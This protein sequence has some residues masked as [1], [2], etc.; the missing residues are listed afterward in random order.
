M[1]SVLLR[2]YKK[3][4]EIG[5]IDLRNQIFDS[6]RHTDLSKWRW[7]YVNTPQGTS[8]IFLYED[9]KKIVGHYALIPILLKYKDKSVISGK[10]E[11][12]MMHKHYRGYGNRFTKL[13]KKGNEI[14]HDEGIDIIWGFPNQAALM[15]HVKGGYDYIGDTFSS[16]KIVN[17][18]DFLEKLVPSYIKSRFISQIVISLGSLLFSS[19]NVFF[20]SGKSK[21]AKDLS[22]KSI[23]K[24]DKRLNNLWEK[25]KNDY[26]IT[27]VRSYEYLNW[28]FVENPCAKS[29]IFIAEKGNEIAGYIVLGSYKSKK[30]Q[31]EAGIISDFFFDK[32]EKTVLNALLNSAIEYFEG[33]QVAYIAVS[34]VKDSYDNKS[35]L[36]IFK[37]KGFLFKSRKLTSPFIVKTNPE[38]ADT[39]Y[40]NDIKNWY[41][42]HAFSEG[43]RF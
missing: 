31:T 40:V 2:R 30:D 36:K 29:K 28:R 43:V 4:D 24:F 1:D 37:K 13:V 39:E 25:V 34:M 12:A 18:R 6:S 23:S 35:F 11:D 19:L 27:V 8:K 17:I 7:E 41:I 5:I 33:K 20:K 3:G 15:P 21:H 10:S 22:I 16:I 32:K 14:S 38:K 26:G 42:T 9:K